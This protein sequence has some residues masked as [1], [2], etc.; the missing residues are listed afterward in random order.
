M[1]NYFR[2]MEQKIEELQPIASPFNKYFGKNQDYISSHGAK[3][4]SDEGLAALAR[5]VINCS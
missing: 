3:H 2:D 5:R 1:Q 4:A